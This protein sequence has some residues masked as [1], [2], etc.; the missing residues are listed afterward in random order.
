MI[1]VG[2]IIETRYGASE[3]IQML[4][5]DSPRSKDGTKTDEVYEDDIRCNRVVFILENGHWCYS[6]QVYLP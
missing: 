4:I 1:K 5:T 2:D 6:D 3:I